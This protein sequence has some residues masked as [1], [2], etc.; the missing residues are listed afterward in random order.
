MVK[1]L[2][3]NK[4][5]IIVRVPKLKEMAGLHDSTISNSLSS[6]HLTELWL[7]VT[8]SM[9]DLQASPEIEAEANNLLTGLKRTT[10]PGADLTESSHSK[11]IHELAI[12]SVGGGTIPTQL[13]WRGC[14]FGALAAAAGGATG[15]AIPVACILG[16]IF[17]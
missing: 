12:H 2:R 15:I 11:M 6:E 8:R 1:W 7:N 3:D 17:I 14:A 4:D 13:S 16:S 5:E 10:V 9:K